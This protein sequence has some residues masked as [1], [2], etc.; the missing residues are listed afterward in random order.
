MAM[1]DEQYPTGRRTRSAKDRETGC[2][3]RS[4]ANRE[5]PCRRSYDVTSPPTHI[6]GNVAQT[7]STASAVRPAARGDAGRERRCQRESH[8]STATVWRA[9]TL[10]VPSATL[11]SRHTECA[12]C[13]GIRL[14]SGRHGDRRR[15]LG[16][17]LDLRIIVVGR[18]PASRIRTGRDRR[19]AGNRSC[20]GPA[21]WGPSIPARWRAR[22]CGRPSGPKNML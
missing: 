12:Y 15:A 2:S 20:R 18:L 14:R 4:S 13:I 22:D 16:R 17:R 21:G 1:L 7:N 3:R 6:S 9:A 10:R 19:S 11:Q 5:P 8:A